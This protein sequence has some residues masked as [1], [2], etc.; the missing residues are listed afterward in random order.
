MPVRVV[1]SKQNARLKELRR[2]LAAS[3]RDARGRVGLEGSNLLEEALRAGVRVA[4][5]FVAQ[6]SE[7]LLGALTV[8]PEIDILLVPRE[9]LD[10]ALATETP[11]PIAALVEPPDWTWA[12]L[13]S[14][15]RDSAALVVVLA[16]IQDPGNLGTMVRSA[17]AFGATGIVSLPGTVSAWNPKAVRASA[18]SIFRVPLL[19][20]SE[21]ECFEE[22]REAGVKVFATTVQAAQPADL[23]DLAGPVALIIG[24]EGNGVPRKLASHADGALT[25]PCPG[26]VESLNAAVAASVLLYEAARQRSALSGGP[27]D[28]RGAR[29]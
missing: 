6:G 10:S 12:H 22:L 21:R 25:I 14:T 27:L 2:A 24:N 7:G 11:Q 19:C 13:L 17:E 15:P 9:L 4:T 1:E 3:G 29:R 18:G 26:P 28:H 16:G 8:P 23:A 5:I 20:A